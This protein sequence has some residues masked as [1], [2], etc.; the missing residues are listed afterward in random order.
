MKM[1][2]T[3]KRWL[4]LVLTLQACGLLADDFVLILPDGV[5]PDVGLMDLVP[6]PPVPAYDG[7]AFLFLEGADVSGFPFPVDTWWQPVPD[8]NRIQLLRADPGQAYNPDLDVSLN[9]GRILARNVA[10]GGDTYALELELEQTGDS[11]QAEVEEL[12]NWWD[13][14]QQ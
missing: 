13:L 9:R 5:P 8:T 6:N 1:Q 4:P 10:L 3:S 11:I 12:V 7:N 2:K 14:G